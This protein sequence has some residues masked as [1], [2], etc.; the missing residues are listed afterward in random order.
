MD[1]QPKV[2]WGE[3]GPEAFAAAEQSGSPVLLS[4]VAPWSPE[5]A[6]MDATT[7]AE[8]RI[9][10]HVND[11]FVPVRVD[12]DRRPR[13]R[14]RYAMGGFPS[15]VFL[16]P[17]GQVLTGATYLGID[18]FRDIL[19]RVRETWDANGES[20]GSVPRQLRETD[21]PGG[22]LSPRIEER[23]VEQLLAAYDEEFGGWGAD[24]K[25][26][27][28]R[29]IEFALVRA[30][31]QATRTL[32]AVRTH[33]LDTY[34]GGFYRHATERDWSD[35]RRAKLLDDNAALIRAFAH[36]Y[37]YTG[38]EAYRE[39]AERGIEYLTTT[40]WTDDAPGA[41][42]AFA[43]SQAGE[44]RYYRLDATDRE[45]ADPPPVDGTAFADRNALAVDALC[46]YYAYTDDGRSRRFAERALE[47]VVELIDED[48]AVAHFSGAESP[49]GL[50][51][52]QA[53]VLAGLT[54]VWQV[55]GDPGPARAVADWTLEHLAADGPLR[56]GPSGE[57]GLLD[58]P[59]YPFDYAVEFASAALDLAALA[60]EPA[61]REHAHKT[62]A[63]YA[64][65]ADRMG[66]EAAEYATAVA[67][68]LEPRT[69]RV[70]PPAGS[71]LHRAALR[72]ADHEAVVVPG[73]GGAS[74]TVID[75]ETPV[76]T[77]ETP[78]GLESVL[79]GG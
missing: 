26:P 16:T 56:D 73:V 54:T 39:A 40:L 67:R 72:L 9:A 25:F 11:G 60:E 32:E 18:G 57:T 7:Y 31:E 62:V 2:E 52:D 5:C 68:V 19:D 1:E 37:R 38:E 74:A 12:A 28:P 22:S 30:R 23:M 24:V 64:N 70:G 43:A 69:I 48:G 17:S 4:L 13:V 49:R 15:T 44:A 50:L 14:D 33:L 21:P 27:L 10:A 75:G 45:D 51:I 46:T 76:G 36:G 65:A 78:A 79:T 6:A 59:L 29:T 71:D 41:S 20:G 47:A 8:P 58:R 35:P 66:V 77:A 42:G 34:D 61:Y 3:W 63:T 53:R 55:L